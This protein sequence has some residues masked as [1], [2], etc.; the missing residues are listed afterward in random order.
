VYARPEHDTRTKRATGEDKVRT[1]F[2][3][4]RVAVA[5]LSAVSHDLRTPLASAKAAVDT[6]RSLDAAL[7]DADRRELVDTADESLTRLGRLVENL[8]DV[9]RLQVGAL[10]ISLQLVSLAEAIPR[11]VDE[12]GS[13]GKD[14]RIQVPDDLP[15]VYADAALLESALVNLL[16]NAL[17]HGRAD[18]LPLITASEHGGKVEIRVVDH[19]PGVR[20][21]DW[22]RIFLPF[23]RL[24]GCDNATGVGLGL[25][26]SRDL[27]EAMD[28]TITPEAT[29]GG[30]LTMALSLPAADPLNRQRAARPED[31]GSGR[32]PGLGAARRHR[33]AG[34]G[35]GL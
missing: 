1:E 2:S 6:L 12:L 24:G 23:Q 34:T 11:S 5:L 28:G 31:G 35:C 29:P 3:S 30:G 15:E 20:P 32:L 14:V 26:L 33:L 19:G 27:V 16:S 8:L 9:N 18:Q 17:C 21:A 10:A 4:D 13:A 25:A 7:S 22:D